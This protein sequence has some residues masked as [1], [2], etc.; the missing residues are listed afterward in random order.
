MN[1]I[2]IWTFDD[3]VK[4]K[5]SCGYCYNTAKKEWSNYSKGH[6]F[7]LHFTS[8]NK[9][10]Q[11][12]SVEYLDK[13]FERNEVEYSSSIFDEFD[14]QQMYAQGGI[15]SDGNIKIM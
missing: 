6:N 12:Y 10:E 9:R 2:E 1:N 3:F 8:E 15:I 11:T 7:V 5:I 14:R 13:I 4:Y